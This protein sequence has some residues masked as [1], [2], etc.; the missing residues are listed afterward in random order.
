M[1]RELGSVA[2]WATDGTPA[3][4]FE[5]P[6]NQRSQDER[7]IGLSVVVGQAD[8]AGLPQV[9]LPAVQVPGRGADVEENHI[10]T[11][12]DQPSAKMHLK[13]SRGSAVRTG[14]SSCFYTTDEK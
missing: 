3:D 13:T 5:K 1:D 14:W 9:A 11:A 12:L 6:G 4:L 8:A 2:L 10:R 7:I